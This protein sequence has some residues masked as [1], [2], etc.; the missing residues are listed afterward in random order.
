MALY[1]VGYAVRRRI[2]AFLLGRYDIF[3]HVCTDVG[4]EGKGTGNWNSGGTF[5]LSL[6]LSVK[7]V[8]R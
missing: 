7:G 4:R 2:D 5:S 3:S 1:V 8:A 6:S